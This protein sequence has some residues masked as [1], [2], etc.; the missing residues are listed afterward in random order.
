MMSVRPYR[1]DRQLVTGEF[2]Q[3]D[4]TTHMSALNHLTTM[5]LNDPDNFIEQVEYAVVAGSWLFGLAHEDS[6]M[7]IKG[8]HVLPLSEILSVKGDRETTGRAGTRV[9]LGGEQVE[10]QEIEKFINGCI[11]NNPTILEVLFAD[12]Q[13]VLVLGDAARE[14][15]EHSDRFLVPERIFQAFSNYAISQVDDMKSKL[16]AAFVEEEAVKADSILTTYDFNKLD[17]KKIGFGVHQLDQD[18]LKRDKVK[19]IANFEAAYEVHP[20]YF[21]ERYDT[22]HAAHS[23]RLLLSGYHCLSTGQFVTMPPNDGVDFLRKIRKDEVSLAGFFEYIYQMFEKVI[24][25]REN[26]AW[27]RDEPDYEFINDLLYTVRM[28]SR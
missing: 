16:W 2:R 23:L 1:K 9:H 25:A 3:W 21:D 4:E 5:A 17:F 10:F 28:R 19:R 24:E 12:E 6:D 13:F 18:K 26:P 27:E 8:F 22:K 14:L 7:D 20:E 15:R 11:A